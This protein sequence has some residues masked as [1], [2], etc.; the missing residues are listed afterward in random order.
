MNSNTAPLNI[1]PRPLQ[2]QLPQRQFQP[3]IV[4]PQLQKQSSSQQI[5]IKQNPPSHQSISISEALKD[6]NPSK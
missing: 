5:N 3:I 1:P 2:Q 6:L 4:H